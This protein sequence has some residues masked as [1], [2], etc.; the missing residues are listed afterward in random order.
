MAKNHNQHHTVQQNHIFS[1]LCLLFVFFVSCG[2]KDFLKNLISGI[3]DSSA[4]SSSTSLFCRYWEP[5]PMLGP[6]G[7][8]ESR[9][10]SSWNFHVHWRRWEVGRQGHSQV[11]TQTDGRHKWGMCYAEEVLR[12]L[13]ASLKELDLLEE[14]MHGIPKPRSRKWGGVTFTKRGRKNML[15]R[16]HAKALW[17]LLKGYSKWKK[18]TV[19]EVQGVRMLVRWQ[20]HSTIALGYCPEQ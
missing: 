14:I 10:L 18:A 12:A 11:I 8:A 13:E 9:A 4:S 16:W 3:S 1:P 7:I 5:E 2:N 20:A 15:S 19:T 6:G 17:W